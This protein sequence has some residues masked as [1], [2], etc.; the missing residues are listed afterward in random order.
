[1]TSV[2]KIAIKREKI[3]VLKEHKG[4][5]QKINKL[6]KDI[7]QLENV[8]IIKDLLKSI[9]SEKVPLKATH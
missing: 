5:E 4:K 2:E 7:K 3:K 6:N 1:M 9:S 8:E